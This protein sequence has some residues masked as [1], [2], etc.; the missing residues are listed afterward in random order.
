[1]HCDTTVPFVK[2]DSLETPL[3]LQKIVDLDVSLLG[4]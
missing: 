3:I 2:E 1:M 4:V